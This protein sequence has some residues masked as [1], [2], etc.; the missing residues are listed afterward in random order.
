MYDDA[1]CT[2]P[3]TSVRMWQDLSCVPQ[4]DHYN[5]VCKPDKSGF[6]VSDC[7]VG[8]SLTSSFQNTTDGAE[9][10]TRCMKPKL[11]V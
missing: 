11:T 7:R 6:S 10:Q 4:K 2:A 8:G 1:S 5:P 9:V 3:A